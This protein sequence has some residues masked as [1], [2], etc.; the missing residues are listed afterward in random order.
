MTLS[1]DVIGNGIFA[2]T[3]ALVGALITISY[4]YYQYRCQLKKLSS[5]MISDSKKKI[6]E[7][8]IKYRFVLLESRR[9]DPLPTMHFNA[10]LSAIPV[11]FSKNKECMDKYRVIGDKFTPEKYYDLVVSLMKDVPL[12][13][14]AIDKHLLE[15]VPTV[16][17]KFG[18]TC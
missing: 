18:P 5:D 4:Q 7:D 8:L 17:P 9:N 6:I 14:D 12:G 16:T 1:N 3:G 10:A 11:H 2:L 13:V 15:N